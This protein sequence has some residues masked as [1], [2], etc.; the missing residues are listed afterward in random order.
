M[1]H[2]VIHA[3]NRVHDNSSKNRNRNSHV[4][5]VL[6][7]VDVQVYVGVCENKTARK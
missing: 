6:K 7:Y 1:F 2:L 3:I 4:M 5:V